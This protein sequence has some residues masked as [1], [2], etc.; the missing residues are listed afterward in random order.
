MA[1]IVIAVL[2]VGAV[3]AFLF[4]QQKRSSGLQ[5]RFGSE[6]DRAVSDSGRLKGEQE[7]HEREKRVEKLNIVP[8]TDAARRGY[9]ESWRNVQARFVDEPG[10]AIV[11]ADGL[12]QRVMAERGYPISD[13]DQRVADISV[14][15]ADVADNYREAHATSRA[16]ARGG[17]STEQLR[18]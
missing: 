6:Y 1:I 7:L 3:A 11:E 4:L 16:Q 9:A 12:V 5:E 2:L 10:G 8:L 18:Q 14:D 15:H 17:V 13:F